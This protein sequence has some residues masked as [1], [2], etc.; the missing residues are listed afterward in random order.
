MAGPANAPVWRGCQPLR[1]QGR[2]ARLTAD[3][4]QRL[5]AG[6]GSQGPRLYDWVVIPL[7]PP[8]TPGWCRWLLARRRLEAPTALA[9]DVVSAPE[10]PHWR[11]WAGWQGA[12][13]ALRRV[14]KRPRGKSAGISLTGAWGRPGTGTSHGRGEPRRVSR[15]SVLK[16]RGRPK[17]KGGLAADQLPSIDGLRHGC[18][19]ALTA[20]GAGRAA[21]MRA[22]C[23]DPGPL[24]AAGARVVLLASPASGHRDV[25]P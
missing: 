12:A 21:V 23:R 18:S 13:G 25:F 7:T 10:P 1:G 20:N 9:D 22:V 4:W 24:V 3:A 19:S 2:I 6:A 15:A 16:R 11:R 14:G 5:R 17:P 8:W